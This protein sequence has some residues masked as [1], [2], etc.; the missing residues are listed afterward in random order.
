MVGFKVA[1]GDRIFCY[2]FHGLNFSEVP[3]LNT[4]RE[5]LPDAS[6]YA[7]LY[8]PA[9]HKADDRFIHS[10]HCT[11]DLVIEMLGG[12]LSPGRL[13]SWGAGLGLIEQRLAEA[14]WDVDAVEVIRSDAWPKQVAWFASLDGVPDRQYDAVITISTLYSQDDA[15]CAKLFESFVERLRPGGLIL[16]AEQDS[17]SILGTLRGYIARKLVHERRSDSQLWGFL[18]VPSF[19][20]RQAKMQHIESRFFALNGDWSFTRLKPPRRIFGR[21]LLFRRSRM[22]FHLLQKV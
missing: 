18:R 12:H 1:H 17:R 7:A 19:Y 16:L 9:Q 11:A 2:D 4:S 8:A 3:G 14:G 13:L 5:R 15:A 10:K 20:L 22:Y 6:F 21:Q